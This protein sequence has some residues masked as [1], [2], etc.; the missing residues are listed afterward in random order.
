MF[1]LKRW[2]SFLI[3]TFVSSKEPFIRASYIQQAHE[4]FIFSLVLSSESKTSLH[5]NSAVTK[6][7][8]IRIIT[9]NIAYVSLHIRIVLNLLWSVKNYEP[10]TL[11]CKT[12]NE[13]LPTIF[14]KLRNAIQATEIC[15]KKVLFFFRLKSLRL[16]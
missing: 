1:T 10:L 14:R 9:Q 3:P 12:V 13:K 6:C 16:C 7:N 15:S 8:N 5:M 4:N 11:F 2:R